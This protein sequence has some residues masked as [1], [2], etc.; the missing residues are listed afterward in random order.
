ML[1][2][3]WSRHL[4]VIVTMIVLFQCGNYVRANLILIKLT[5]NVPLLEEFGVFAQMVDSTVLFFLQFLIKL[6]ATMGFK[7]SNLLFFDKFMF[8]F[9]VLNSSGKHSNWAS[10]NISNSACW[11]SLTAILWGISVVNNI[12]FWISHSCLN[13][14]RYAICIT[15]FFQWGIIVPF[16]KSLI[17][18]FVLDKII[19]KFFLQFLKVCHYQYLHA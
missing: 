17:L 10:L 19:S 13:F 7:G 3:W 15:S 8:F 11:I 9:K 5:E 2:L 1:Y 6:S 14:K 18:N 12:R 4:L 16:D